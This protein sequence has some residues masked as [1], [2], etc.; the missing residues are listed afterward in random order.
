MRIPFGTLNT[1]ISKTIISNMPKKY[2]KLVEP[3]GDGGTLALE[4]KKKKPKEHLVNIENEDLFFALSFVQN[5]SGSDKSKL[6]KFDWVGSP[7]TFDQVMAINAEAGPERF[8]KFLYVKKFG[9]S[10]EPEEPPVF[11]I[12]SN[13]KDIS[14]LLYALPLMKIGLKKVTITNEDPLNII[15]SNSSGDSFLVLLPKSPDH[16]GA[17]ESRLNSLSGNF[18]FAAKRKDVDAIIEDAKKYKNLSVAPLSVASI[19]MAK[20]SV[21]SNYENELKPI[22]LEN[23]M[24][25]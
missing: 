14:H 2:R 12:L 23:S 16:I 21:I 5:I 25:M 20:M 8:Y 6:K 24:N 7:E 11:D 17:V 9:M 3:F 4:L 22:D 18:F 19:M 10:M 15:S 13:G 1:K